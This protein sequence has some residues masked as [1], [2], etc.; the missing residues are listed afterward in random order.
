M[1]NKTRI[2]LAW[3][4]YEQGV[5]RT[6]IAQQ[7]ERHRETVGLWIKGIEREGLAAF[8]DSYD[9]AKKVPR[10]KRQVDAITKR[11]V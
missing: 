5:P 11:R 2:V 6:H 10:R 7:L 3:E 9:Q 1:D 8:L 4:L